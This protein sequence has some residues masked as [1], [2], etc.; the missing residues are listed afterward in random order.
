MSSHPKAITVP[1]IPHF[2][3]QESVAFRYS[4]VASSFPHIKKPRCGF[5][6]APGFFMCSLDIAG[7]GAGGEQNLLSLLARNA[8]HFQSV[9]LLEGEH[10]VGG[11]GVVGAGNVAVVVLQLV[12]RVLQLLTLLPVSPCCSLE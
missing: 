12:Q 6:S 10:R 9:H 5:L 4:N 2:T 8:V 11:G 1:S 3:Q 7:N